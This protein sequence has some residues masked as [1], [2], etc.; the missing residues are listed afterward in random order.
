[1]QDLVNRF[2][3][4]FPSPPHGVRAGDSDVILLTGTTGA[5]GSYALACLA[6][7]PK[8]SRI[9]AVN[10]F[11]RQDQAP[12]LDMQLSALLDRDIDSKLVLGT[13]KVRFLEADLTVPGFKLSEEVYKEV[14]CF[15]NQRMRS[16]ANL[17]ALDARI[18]NMYNSQR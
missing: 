18:R 16:N 11:R 10:R 4:D 9:Y 8:V 3:C 13:G 1:M 17:F 2:S 7:S 5:L 15:T 12:L 14:Q 6:S